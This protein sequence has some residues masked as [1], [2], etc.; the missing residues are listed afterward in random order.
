[1]KRMT[2]LLSLVLVL[3]LVACGPQ[4]PTVDTAAAEINVTEEDVGPSFTLEEE[5]GLQDLLETIDLQETSSVKDAQLRY[6]SSEA[7]PVTTVLAA[8]LVF[9][10][11]G[12]ARNGLG[13]LRQGF[14]DSLKKD[15]P[16]IALSELTV[17][18]GDE[19]YFARADFPGRNSVVY[20]LLVRKSNVLS[21]V[22][23]SGSAG[24]LDENWVRD[25]G[26]KMLSRV[27]QPQNP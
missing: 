27:P 4:E 25:L 19:T 10:S 26:Q 20:L 7:E 5:S 22:T 23:A 13:E 14:T 12:N 2:W 9:D 8:V 11:A 16:D 15:A 17:S 21:M 6:Y 1:M 18:M 3:L 24:S